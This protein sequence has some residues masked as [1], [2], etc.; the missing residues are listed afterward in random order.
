MGHKSSP[1]PAISLPHQVVFMSTLSYNLLN[2]RRHY[3]VSDF[4]NALKLWIINANET[5]W[6]VTGAKKNQ[7]EHRGGQWGD[8]FYFAF[9][10]FHSRTVLPS[11]WK[12]NRHSNWLLVGCEQTH[13]SAEFTGQHPVE[14]CLGDLTVPSFFFF[15]PRFLSKQK[16]KILI[17]HWE[18]TKPTEY[19]CGRAGIHAPQLDRQEPPNLLLKA[20]EVC[21]WEHS[22]VIP[23]VKCGW[24]ET[25]P[26]MFLRN[27]SVNTDKA[28]KVYG[29]H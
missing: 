22:E 21:V 3:I 10:A 12:L 4:E 17:Y 1:G 19:V 7:Y 29:T 6:F 15:S 28:S 14:R 18:F 27:K 8:C 5:F 13:A 24:P 11:C 26:L 25:L 9:R 23:P 2:N 20:A 16:Y